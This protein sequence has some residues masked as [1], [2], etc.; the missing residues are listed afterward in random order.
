MPLSTYALAD[1]EVMQLVAVRGEVVHEDG[2]DLSPHVG[3]V[4]S[5]GDK[6]SAHQ[7]HGLAW[8]GEGGGKTHTLQPDPV[9]TAGCQSPENCG[10]RE[11]RV[12]MA[13]L[14]GD[15][16]TVSFTRAFSRQC[17][18]RQSGWLGKSPTRR[19]SIT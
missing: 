13:V 11:G 5:N 8:E 19:A 2:R 18:P 3:S 4:R 1:Q 12:A 16:L 10:R 6:S 15:P 17:R 7:T 9:A 14:L